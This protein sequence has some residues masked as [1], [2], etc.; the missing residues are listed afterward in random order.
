M[1]R[2]NK[3]YNH[4]L[5]RERMSVITK[6]ELNRKFCCHNIEHSLD[7]ARIGYIMILEQNLNIDK[8]LFYAAALLHDA[9]RYSGMPH[10][11]SGA[12]LASAIMTECDFTA[13]ETDLVCKAISGHRTDGASD[14]FSKVLYE[15][16]K[17]SRLCFKCNARN[18]CYWDDDKKNYEILI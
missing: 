16:D 5:Y 8:E 17:K 15:A 3:I 1:Q 18:D 7:V 4:T 2:C 9:G 14:I 10:N 13:N 12:I 11:E 6:K